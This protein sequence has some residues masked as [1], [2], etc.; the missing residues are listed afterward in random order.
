MSNEANKPIVAITI[1]LTV[2]TLSLSSMSCSSTKGRDEA[3][4]IVAL[5]DSALNA[6]N[7]NLADSLLK[8][9]NRDY[10]DQ[11]DSRRKATHLMARVNEGMTLREMEQ[12]D[13]MLAVLQSRGDSLQRNLKWIDNDIE[14]YYIIQGHGNNPD[15]T[16]G[17]Q[18]RIMK[19]GTLYMI[20]S[21]AGRRVNHTSVTLS[22]DGASVSGPVIPHDGE[23]NDRSSGTE[24]IT[25]SGNECYP[26]GK[27][28]SQ[29]LQSPVSVTF[30]GNSTTTITLSRQQAEA[31]ATA[32]RFSE[33]MSEF[34]RRTLRKTDLE[35]KLNMARARTAEK[36]P[37][38][39]PESN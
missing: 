6:G 23:R 35:R 18:A 36:T 22:A 17:L 19:D 14:G 24:I 21:C 11:L 25:Y 31:I 32:F 1:L 12:N 5:A 27:F 16:T 8:H 3:E 7:V 13:S 29:H 2:A 20:S 4:K 28:V 39:T 38:T 9:L 10:H 15:G 33:T 30:N 37:E 34:K 26:M